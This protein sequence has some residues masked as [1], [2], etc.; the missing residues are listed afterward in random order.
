[1]VIKVKIDFKKLVFSIGITFLIGGFFSIFTNM[2]FYQNLNKPFQL[3]AIVFP[4]VWSILYFLMGISLYLVSSSNHSDKNRAIAI[5]YVQ[6]IV[7]SLWTLFFFGFKWF[8]FSFLWILL[9]MFLVFLMIYQFYR[10][11][12]MAAYLNIPYL[13]WLLFAGY[14]NFSI[15]YLN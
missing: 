9:L 15:Y 1:M 4:I 3:P 7:N 13:L 6:L 2:D 12:K 10:I 5:Y 14:L 11:N 8:L